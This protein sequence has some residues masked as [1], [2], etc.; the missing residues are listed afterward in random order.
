MTKI[1]RLL[2]LGI[3]FI[4]LVSLGYFIRQDFSFLI[5]DFWFTSGLL[6]LILLSLID[7]P[8]FSK[9]TNVFVNAVTAAIS[10]LLVK[11]ENRDFL[12]WTFL[13]FIIYLTVSS[14]I[15]MWLR[16]NPLNQE[17]KGIQFFSRLNRQLGRPEAIFSAFFLWGG[18][19]QFGITSNEFNIL[20]WFW[21]IFM[22]LNIPTLAKTIEGIFIKMKETNNQEAIGQIFGVQSKNTFLVKLSEDRTQTTRIFD[23]VEFKYSIDNKIKK[24][25]I[26]DV[27]LLNQEQWVKVLTT[28]E[29]ERIFSNKVLLTSHTPDFVYKITEIPE[30]DYLERLIGLITENSTIEKIKFIYNSKASITEGQLLELT[31]RNERVLYQVV[32]GMTRIEL[33][34]NKNQ[35]GLIIVEAIQLGTWNNETL[36]FEQFGWVPSINTPVYLATNIDDVPLEQSEYIIGNIPGTNY[37]VILNKE[38]AITHH[39]A[40]LGVTG[41]GKSVFTRNLIRQVVNE[42]TK[43]IVIDLTGE[44]KAKIEDIQPI[45]SEDNANKAFESIELI[46]AEERKFPN[47]RDYDLIKA[48][49]EVIKTE[50]YNS[51][52]IFLEGEPNEAIFELPD[53]SNNSGIIEYTKWFFWVLFKTAKTKQSFGKRVC[54]VL[55]EA[56]TIVPELNS[57]GVSDFASKA[58]VNSIAQIALQGRKY[59]IGFFVIAQRTA[60]VS[61]TVLTQCN[62]I[63]VFQ[64]FDKT[65]SD[66]LSNYLGWE[67]IKVLPT[68]KFRQ[69]IA[70]GKAFKS[71]VPMIFEVPNLD[72]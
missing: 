71:N 17:R 33:L 59:N 72:T 70:V 21:I 68:L 48:Q 4:L 14:Y 8:H 32:E 7:Q 30:T 60:N 16:Q 46:A 20:L 50:F 55:E 37:P 15:L 66:F 11:S 42:T 53:I 49:E 22:I 44:Y 29:I 27:Y 67:F 62:S 3:S 18:I 64:E 26:L 47:Q 10:L 12:F 23:F 43:V 6:L 1:Y 35:T 41:S 5:D 31:V 51:I 39:T 28:Q 2:L 63:I 25:L 56:H 58:T 65:S 19:R 57:M 45:I 38:V 36:R 54:V 52:K 13:S 9:D 69:A 34:E 61:K 40:I 24:G